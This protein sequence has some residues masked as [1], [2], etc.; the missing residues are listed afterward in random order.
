M[1]QPN[2]RARTERAWL[3]AASSVVLSGWSIW[4]CRLELGLRVVVRYWRDQCPTVPIVPSGVGQPLYA[5]E[6]MRLLS[7]CGLVF[8]I[9]ALTGRPRWP[10]VAAVLLALAALAVAGAIP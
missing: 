9:V 3:A 5:L 1:S 8:A 6:S 4:Y 10:G 2:G 7:V